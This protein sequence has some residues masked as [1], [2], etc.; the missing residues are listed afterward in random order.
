MKICYLARASSVHTQRWARHFSGRGWDVTV[1]SFEEGEIDGVHVIPI[2]YKRVSRRINILLGIRKIQRLLREVNPDILH[3]HYVTSYGLAGALSG[4]HPFVATGWG[5]DILIE[6]EKS[7]VYRQMVHYS[8]RR[9]DL[10]TSMAPHMTDLMIRRGY[11]KSEKIITLPFGVDTSLFSPAMRTAGHK[12]ESCLVVSTRRLDTGMDVDVFIKA[13]PG[14]IQNVPGTRFCIVGDGPL[15]E[16]LESLA[17]ELNVSEFID[18][19]GEIKQGQM[20]ELLGKADVFVSTS[21][22]DGNNISL[23]EAMACGAFPVATDIA[24]NRSWIGQGEN[25]LLFPCRDSREL[26]GMVSEALKRCEWR[27]AVMPVNWDIIRT[28]ASWDVHMECMERYYRSLLNGTMP[29]SS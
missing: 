3:A 15:R 5:S 12:L 23:N 20:C 11:A 10:V 7:W 24:A 16:S 14:I 2:K 13:I 21:P 17:A 29:L 22:S 8:L 6:P 28:K 26:A 1:I 18:F 27:Q 9:A 19:I 25:G 4:I